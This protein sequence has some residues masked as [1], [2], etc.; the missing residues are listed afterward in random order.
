[1]LKAPVA[2][3]RTLDG[4]AILSRRDADQARSR[5]RGRTSGTGRL[6][7]LRKPRY[8]AT[9]IKT[10]RSPQ[11]DGTNPIRSGGEAEGSRFRPRGKESSGRG[12]APMKACI[13]VRL[14]RLE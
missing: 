10:A 4:R 13:G 12:S 1:M 2:A 3:E 9:G 8:A 6:L 11:L 7:V 14:A 5:E